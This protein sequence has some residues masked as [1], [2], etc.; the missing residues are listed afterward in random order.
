MKQ[1]ILILYVLLAWSGMD[2]A[3]AK[4]TQKNASRSVLAT[5]SG[6]QSTQQVYN[7]LLYQQKQIGEQISNL[8]LQL[9]SASP[10]QGRKMTR[11]I[12]LL[13]DDLAIVER[14]LAAFP[15]QFTG[16]TIPQSEQNTAPDDSFRQQLD[17]LAANR[18]AASNPFAGQLSADPE[19][20]RMYR[21]YIKVY[22][23]GVTITEQVETTTGAVDAK[24][25]VYRVMV[26]ISKTR[27]PLATFSGISDIVEQ[28]MPA[29]GYVYYAGQYHSLGVAQEACDQI[30]S[31][32]KFRD[33]F[34]VAMQG[35]KRVPIKK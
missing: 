23:D 8:S 33:A 6:T 7:D 24:N 10:A 17:S 12:N 9:H 29:G 26:A 5:S 30:L 28:A 15:A 22:G 18:V 25:L 3:W 16:A 4:K 35:G 14:K 20:D 1:F 11:Q 21:A 32:H 31:R 34:V 27:L 19:L 2:T 13:S